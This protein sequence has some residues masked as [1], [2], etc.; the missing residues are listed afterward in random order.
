MHVWVHFGV[1]PPLHPMTDPLRWARKSL[2]STNAVKRL[3]V[4]SM[5][6]LGRELA[7]QP[8]TWHL[9]VSQLAF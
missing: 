6:R 7:E 1:Q 8:V 9:E 2:S 4:S 3:T 5:T